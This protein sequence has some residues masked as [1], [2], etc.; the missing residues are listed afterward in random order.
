M[1]AEKQTLPPDLGDSSEGMRLGVSAR[2]Q[3]TQELAASPDCTN[4]EQLF[5]FAWEELDAQMQLLE[6]GI[7]ELEKLE[8]CLSSDDMGS[9]PASPLDNTPIITPKKIEESACAFFLPAQ[10][11]VRSSTLPNKRYGI[12][13]YSKVG[14]LIS[15]IQESK[16]AL[17]EQIKPE[18]KAVNPSITKESIARHSS[19]EVPH[20]ANNVSTK[21][22][23]VTPVVATSDKSPGTVKTRR[24]PEEY[25]KF[26]TLPKKR[27]T[28]EGIPHQDQALMDELRYVLAQRIRSPGE[29]KGAKIEKHSLQKQHQELI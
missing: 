4:P 22:L 24:P 15:S 27:V 19:V 23:V 12:A 10:Q 13:D 25:K 29:L 20:Q 21:K 8:K 6:Q 26:A 16:D 14:S 1:S 28:F 5:A 18:E 17:A 2:N 9:D 11:N 7:A 3:Q